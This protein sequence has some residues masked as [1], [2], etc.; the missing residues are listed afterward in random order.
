MRIYTK[1]RD[2]ASP[3]KIGYNSEDDFYQM[4]RKQRRRALKDMAQAI[5][6]L[7][8]EYKK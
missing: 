2:M 6:Q 7:T 1:Y 3:E 4:T 8:D 5:R